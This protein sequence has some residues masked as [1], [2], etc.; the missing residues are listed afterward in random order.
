MVTKRQCGVTSMNREGTTGQHI[1]AKSGNPTTKP[2]SIMLMSV[3]IDDIFSKNVLRTNHGRP[4]YEQKQ[5]PSIIART[6]RR[7]NNR[8]KTSISTA[9]AAAF[10]RVTACDRPRTLNKTS[11][12][13][14][15]RSTTYGPRTARRLWQTS[16][17]RDEAAWLGRRAFYDYE[18]VQDSL[19]FI[20]G[21]E[22]GYLQMRQRLLLAP[23]PNL[24]K[25]ALTC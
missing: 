16:C 14:T 10:R 23:A 6:L 1:D 18:S 2:N 25:L 17:L 13:T 11:D 12:N 3:T 21:G 22:R 7:S 24:A 9:R 8:G 15:T 19:W 5:C 20:L 4:K